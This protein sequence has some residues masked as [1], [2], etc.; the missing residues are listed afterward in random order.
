MINTFD[1]QHLL[2]IDVSEP[3]IRQKYSDCRL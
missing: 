1:S 3:N 2:L